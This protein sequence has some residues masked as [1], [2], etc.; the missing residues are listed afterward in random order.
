MKKYLKVDCVFYKI[1]V[2]EVDTCNTTKIIAVK[3]RSCNVTNEKKKM[4][5][6][7]CF[8]LVEDGK[9]ITFSKKREKFK[10]EF[11]IRDGYLYSTN[12]CT[13]DEEDFFET[14]IKLEDLNTKDVFYADAAVKN[15]H[16]DSPF[17]NGTIFKLKLEK[18]IGITSLAQAKKFFK[19]ADKTKLI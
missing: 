4:E 3:N 11:S 12:T 7:Y 10:L 16:G 8:C 15:A 18:I 17:Q 6:S 1:T 9:A 13:C 14:V 19:A 5:G 2:L